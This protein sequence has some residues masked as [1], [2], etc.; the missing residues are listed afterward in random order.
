MAKQRAR[1]ECIIIIDRKEKEFKTT[2]VS[3]GK[4]KGKAPKKTKKQLEEERR[5]TPLSHS[6]SPPR[7]G[8]AR[9]GGARTQATRGRVTEARRRGAHPPRGRG[10]ARRRGTRTS[11]RISGTTHPSH[12]LTER[13]GA[14]LRHHPEEVPRGDGAHGA[15]ERGKW[16]HLSPRSLIHCLT[17]LVGQIPQMQHAARP[18]L[19]ERNHDPPHPVAREER[20]Q[21]R[22]VRAQ[23]PGGRERKHCPS[24]HSHR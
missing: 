1:R 23:L 5:K 11:H 2:M 13:R 21:P 17:R 4:G 19:R 22:R 8:E 9:P 12:T 7:R 3:H 24:L 10:Q 6:R 15:K 14:L 18:L 16:T 20:T